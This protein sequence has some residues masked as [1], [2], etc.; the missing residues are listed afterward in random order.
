[1]TYPS[2]PATSEPSESTLAKIFDGG[3]KWALLREVDAKLAEAKEKMAGTRDEVKVRACGGSGP[4]GANA[5]TAIAARVYQA[6][7]ELNETIGTR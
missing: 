7:D 4:G 2:W 1:M 5:P 6:Q 3:K